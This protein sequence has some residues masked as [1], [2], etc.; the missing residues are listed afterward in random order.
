MTEEKCRF[1]G[2]LLIHSFCD[3]GTSP[4]SN[5]YLS[6]SQLNEVEP[7]YPLHAYVCESCFLVQLPQ[8]QSPKEIFNEYLYLSSYS[9]SWVKHAKTYANKVIRRFKLNQESAVVEIASN[10]GYLLQHFKNRNI[11][12]LGVEPAENV[13]KIAEEKG[14]P[15]R[16][17][18]FGSETARKMVEE[19]ISPDLLVA[20][21]VL[22]HVPDLH[23]FVAGLKILLKPGG[24]IT[25]EFPHL[26]KLMEH[27]QFDTIYHEHFSYFSFLTVDKI[28]YRHQL[29]VY[30]VEELETHG[31]SLRVYLCH[32]DDKTGPISEAVLHL[33]TKEMD[34]GLNTLAPYKAF[35]EK[36]EECRLGFLGFLVS[37]RYDGKKVVAYGA[38]AKGNTLLNYCGIRSDML[39]FTVDR[40]PY[41]QGK[42][43]PGSRI[44]IY[45]P[46]KIKETQPDYVVILPW[47]LKREIMKQLS[48]I[49][50]WNGKFVVPIPSVQVFT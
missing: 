11:P 45:N 22:A 12:V 24:R 35:F 50:E 19:N 30:D 7:W 2:T 5:A 4:L 13:A 47:N 18:F 34:A 46:D 17:G 31:G 1:C 49:R 32:D 42:F 39:S 48:F 41:K 37:L 38:P 25:L 6:S 27:N 9:E 20:N 36:V 40:N 23:D 8:Y 26:L 14:I 44:P 43:L 29:K 3:L 28:F 15:T 10:D 33:R 16:V 21:N